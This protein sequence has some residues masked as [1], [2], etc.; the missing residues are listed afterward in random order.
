[1]RTLCVVAA[2]LCLPVCG[3]A[4]AVRS[5]PRADPPSSGLERRFNPLS[6]SQINRGVSFYARTYLDTANH[7]YFG[8][9]A[10]VEQ[11]QPGDYLVTFGKLGLTPLD[12]ASRYQPSK[13]NPAEWTSQ[14]LPAIPGPQLAHDGDVIHIE[15]FVDAATN[16]KLFDD[17]EIGMFAP[18][19]LP[20]GAGVIFQNPVMVLAPPPPPP[21]LAMSGGLVLPNGR[22]V[23]TV[24]G[25]ARDFTAADAEMQIRQ[26]RVTL[27][28]AAQSTATRTPNATGS[29]IWFYLPGRG[30]YVLSL[31]P[32]PELDFRK[33]GEV[34]GGSIKFT[35]GEDTITLEC[36]NEIASG[37]A[38]YVLYV[39]RDPVWEPTAQAQKGQFAMGSV[40]A[41]EL[42]K[43]KGQ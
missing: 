3:L 30:R 16:A 41:G 34:R 40:D 22:A 32:R 15:L 36:S 18:R 19:A 2:A 21:P 27:N 39:L 20:G 23:P 17:V 8:Y 29:L 33:A 26:P 9:E 28:G 31:A 25:T 7:I 37:H 14:P 35:L 38:P 4:Q 1:M 42:V 10:R 11:L 6:S 12:L 13:I 5:H 43:L 24:E